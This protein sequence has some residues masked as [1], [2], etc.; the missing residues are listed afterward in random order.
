MSALYILTFALLADA[1]DWNSSIGLWKVAEGE[2]LDLVAGALGLPIGELVERNPTLQSPNDV[3]VGELYTVPNLPA[4]SPAAWTSSSGCTPILELRGYLTKQSSTPPHDTNY[5]SVTST[6]AGVS[7]MDETFRRDPTPSRSRAGSYAPHFPYH[8]PNST[9]AS[10]TTIQTSFHT[11]LPSETYQGAQACPVPSACAKPFQGLKCRRTGSLPTEKNAQEA[12][13]VRFCKQHE[14]QQLDNETDS[15]Q[16]SYWSGYNRF[17]RYTISWIPNCTLRRT[18][19]TQQDETPEGP[20]ANCTHIMIQNYQ[21]CTFL[22]M[23]FLYSYV[24]R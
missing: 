1:C 2:C 16:I 10:N 18:Q 19:K 22:S 13:A 8:I 6:E 7:S 21:S 15:V 11:G 24:R 12:Y 17:Y 20:G 5:V 4:Q 23:N 3:T 9:L 14:H